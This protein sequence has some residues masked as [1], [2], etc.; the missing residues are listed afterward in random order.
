MLTIR[1][2]LLNS[3]GKRRTVST[4]YKRRKK[5]PVIACSDMVN[6]LLAD[7]HTYDLIRQ[8]AILK[9]RLKM[10]V[11]ESNLYNDE[12]PSFNR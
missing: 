4:T 5:D 7:C 1:D 8:V 6:A 9:S 2:T 12:E 11:L 10:T 3:Y